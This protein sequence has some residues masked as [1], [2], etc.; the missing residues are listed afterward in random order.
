MIPK[1]SLID[2]QD[3]DSDALSKKVYIIQIQGH[4]GATGIYNLKVICDSDETIT[5]IS[6]LTTLESPYAA[7]CTVSDNDTKQI[8]I[9][10]HIKQN[11]TTCD[12]NATI[13]APSQVMIPDY[14][15]WSLISM[16][17]NT[18]HFKI[19]LG[20][21]WKFASDTISSITLEINGSCGIQNSDCDPLFA[22]SVNE[23][24][25]FAASIKFDQYGRNKISPSC[26]GLLHHGSVNKMVQNS[27]NT[28]RRRAIFNDNQ[29]SIYPSLGSNIKFPAQFTI[30]NN[31]INNTTT[32]TFTHSSTNIIQSCTWSEAFGTKTGLA[33]YISPDSDEE[34][35]N[36][37]SI[38][39]V[40]NG[41]PTTS[42]P[43]TSDT[44]SPTTIAPTSLTLSPSI[45]PSIAPLNPS[46]VPTDIPS[47]PSLDPTSLD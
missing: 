8:S 24:K 45:Y 12:V 10:P 38:D 29:Q 33:L 20:E 40:S 2:T 30:I 27:T 6:S 41:L 25:Y 19:A 42:I 36:I 21:S 5:N 22:F 28:T 47:S 35:L 39:I 7:A 9:L 31:P 15:Q 26:D 16:S 44:Y 1:Q 17:Q 43:P 23:N 11:M 4:N 32:F 14:K 13:L 37:Y 34:I 3:A 46:P 18:W